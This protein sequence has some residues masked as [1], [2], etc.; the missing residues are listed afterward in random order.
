MAC[1]C[2]RIRVGSNECFDQQTILDLPDHIINNLEN[3]EVKTVCIDPCIVDEIKELWELG[4]ITYG[5][6]CGHNYLNP[7]V[8]VDK[9]NIRQMLDMGYV[10]NHTDRMRFDT[11]RLKSLR[12]P[13]IIEVKSNALAIRLKDEL[14]NFNA[15]DDPDDYSWSSQ[16]GLVLSQNQAKIVIDLIRKYG[17]DSILIHDI[18]GKMSPICDLINTA[19]SLLI[20]N[21][22]LKKVDLA[23]MII[24]D[25]CKK[26]VYKI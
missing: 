9:R 12:K 11:F 7:F 21:N 17:S 18:R 22:L 19:N 5:C 3:P 24:N 13:D 14:A 26:E 23:K 6:C 15:K 20:E 10:M 4:I 16:Q 25:L 1:N 2:V 8:N